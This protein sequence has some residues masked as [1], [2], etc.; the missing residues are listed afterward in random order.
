MDE[1]AD[2]E[3]VLGSV[4]SASTFSASLLRTFQKL[5]EAVG[6]ESG[7]EVDNDF[8]DDLTKVVSGMSSS[9]T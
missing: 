1:S 4:A 9:L 2:D 5:P 6:S 7:K 8:V 3:D